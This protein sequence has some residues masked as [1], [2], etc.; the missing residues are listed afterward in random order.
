MTFKTLKTNFERELLFQIITNLRRKKLS[1]KGASYIAKDVLL[2][3][4]EE[5]TEESFLQSVSGLGEKYPEVME[6]FIKSAYEYEKEFKAEKIEEVKNSLNKI[7]I[8]GEN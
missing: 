2:K 7:M 4:K 1:Q 3:I 8:G 6:A 5:S